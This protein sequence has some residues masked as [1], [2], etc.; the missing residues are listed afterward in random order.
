[1]WLLSVVMYVDFLSF[2]FIILLMPVNYSL[3]SQHLY[4]QSFFSWRC[5]QWRCGGCSGGGGGD[6]GGG[7]GGDLC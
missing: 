4:F 6:D 3:S 1:M 5:H 2:E 7:G